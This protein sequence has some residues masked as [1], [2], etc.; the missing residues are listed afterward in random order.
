QAMNTN[1]SRVGPEYF[2]TLQISLVGGRDFDTRDKVGSPNVAIVNEA[3]AR[4]F[5]EGAN[6]V[7]KRFWVAATPNHPETRYEIVGLVGNTKNDD[8]REEFPPTV[9]YAAGQDDGGGPGLQVLVRSR[10]PYDQTVSAMN[11]AL[12]EIN[13]AISV[14]YQS[15]KPMIDATILR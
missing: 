4:R 15:F 13:P 8:L 2:R 10:L 5:F 14:N 6:P 9:Y 12:N 3:F 1:L 7:G 11:R